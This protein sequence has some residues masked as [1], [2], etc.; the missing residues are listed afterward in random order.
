MSTLRTR[1]PLDGDWLLALDPDDAGLGERWFDAAVRKD[2]MAVTV[3]SV[4]DRW[5]PDYDG[6]GWYFRTFTLDENATDRHVDLCFEAV[7][8]HAEVWLNGTRLGSHEGGGTP[9]SFSVSAHLRSG[10][11][12]LAVR[13]I[14]PHG[15]E[16]HVGFR[17][18]TTLNAPGDAH[19]SYAGIWGPVYLESK[20]RLHLEDVFVQ[21]D[22]RR[23]RVTVDVTAPASCQVRLRIENSAFATEAEPGQLHLDFPDFDLWSPEKPVLYTLAVELLDG[24]TVVDEQTVRF[25]M[26]EFSV[27][28]N[29]FYLNSHPLHIKGVVHEPDYPKTLCAPTSE[30]MARTELLCAKEA[31]FNMIRLRGGSPAPLTL[32]LADELG[33]LILEEA[34]IGRLVDSPDLRDRCE[35]VLRETI[36][37]DRNHAS[38]VAWGI[39]NESGSADG[40]MDRGV[41]PITDDLC[42]LARSLDC[43]RLILDDS[44]G[45]G[46][47]RASSRMMRPY[48]DVLEPYDDLHLYQRAPVDFD[49]ESYYRHSGDPESV[50]FL[51]EFGFGGPEDL[52]E[53]LAEY[54]GDAENL[55]DARFIK[56]MYEAAQRGFEERELGRVFGDFAAFLAAARRLQGDAARFQIDA[57]RANPKCA[58]YCYARLASAGRDFCGGVLDRW[59]R[60][61]PVL[62]T[63]QEAQRPVRP[64]IQFKNS[65][66]VPRAESQVTILLANESRVEGRADLSLQVVGPTNQ[67]LWKKKRGVKIPRH[68]K[69]IWTGT[70]AASGSPGTHKFVVR[71]MQGMERIAENSMAFYVHKPV[72]PSGVEIHVL[73]PSN[74]WPR[75]L[76]KLATPRNLLSPVHVIP[77]LANTIRG[78]PDNDLLQVLAQV[79]G[80]AVAIFF[81]PPEDWNSLADV[82]D[83]SLRATPRDAVGDGSM[84]AHYVKMH[85]VFADLSSRCLMRQP[86]RNVIP[87]R[88]F[89]EASDEDICGT[90]DA[91]PLAAADLPGSETPW[92]GSDILVRRYGSGRVVMTHLRILENLGS[93][94]VADQLFVNLLNHFARRSVPSDAPLAIHRPSVEWLRG[95]RENEARRWMV[96]GEFPNWRGAGHEAVYPPEEAQDFTGTYPGWYKAITWK[97]WY[98]LAASGHQVDLQMALAPVYQAYP[99]QDYG[100]AYAYAEFTSDTRRAAMLCLGLYNATK[101]WLNGNLV[102][103]SDG[104]HPLGRPGSAYADGYIKQGKNT[105]LVKSS[106]TPGPSGFSISIEDDRGEALPVKW[107]R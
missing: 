15:P 63:L 23:K 6:V 21:P 9:F 18:R 97:P 10:E 31:G 27:K 68:G 50:F 48:R 51:S 22:I 95:E 55:K 62:K 3:P 30:S 28:D 16:G 39:L 99:R 17:P 80:G 29:R 100:T 78:Y 59:R 76:S 93:D 26:R 1:T 33:I 94:P 35:T 37:R 4:W 75:R 60:K 74:T 84:T 56:A 13:V 92:W 64:I 53:V 83:P 19:W 52:A 82:L 25:G 47:T 44:G 101:V 40:V 69:E 70:V 106:K 66:L 11:N 88:T 45:A 85:P 103:E 57:I 104:Q 41:Q 43:S 32:D 20:A 72:E 81:E 89:A 34:P 12:A 79:H 102:H 38:V 2:A 87:A 49:I 91:R 7:A 54:G 73:D 14:D 67:V 36:V 98:S 86:Y 8:Y 61:K 71:V 105:L 24:E 90:F 58:G 46:F 77:P 96:I 5:A 107:W 42:R 65:N